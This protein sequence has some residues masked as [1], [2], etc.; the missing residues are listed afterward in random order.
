MMSKKFYKAYYMIT[1]KCNLS[2][3]YCVLE[4][5]KIQISKELSL[6]GKIQLIKHLYEKLNFRSITIS[7]GEALI[8]GKKNNFDFE[9]LLLFL[10]DYKSSDATKNLHIHLYTNGTKL[11][12]SI[13]KKMTGIIDEVA[14]NIDSCDNEIL[15]TIGRSKG[16]DNYFDTFINACQKLSSQNIKI[17]LH[18]VIS[19]LNIKPISDEVITIINI[20]IKNKINISSWKFYQYMSYD[21]PLVDERHRLSLKEFEV[22]KGQIKKNLRKY[23][24]KL[25][26]KDNAEMNN[27]LFNILPYGNS[28][29][30]TPDDS[31]ITSKRTDYLINYNSMDEF[32]SKNNINIPMFNKFHSYDPK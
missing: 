27:S 30:M 3:S 6:E 5:S 19:K 20:L 21:M 29:Y 8:I 10:K 1:S 11:S 26:F 2:C 25:H 15:K 14:I 23:N 32:L 9:K 24:L 12:N 18:S 13:V 7:G 4:N 16:N 28:Q 17:E 31:W 22:I